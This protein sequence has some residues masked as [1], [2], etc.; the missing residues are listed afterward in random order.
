MKDII[1]KILN[2]FSVNKMFII[3]AYIN[4]NTYKL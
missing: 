4:K 1:K 2:N 3:L